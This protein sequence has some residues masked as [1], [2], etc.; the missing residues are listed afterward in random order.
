MVQL[1][2]QPIVECRGLTKIFRDFWMRARVTA[3]DDLNL[4]IIPHEVFGLLGPNGSGKSTTIKIILGL[5]FKT[6]GRVTVLG[7]LPTDVAIKKR[8]GYLPEESY[9]YRFLNARETL[10]YYGRLFHLDRHARNRRIDMLLEMV[11]LDA[12]QRRPVGE[13]SK[14]MQ[15]R[16]G[17]AQALINDPD[18]LILDEPTTGLDPIGT[19]QIKDLIVQLRDRGKTVL[20][21]SHLLADVEDV[22]DR[23]TVLYGGRA[24][25]EGTV[26]ELLTQ[27]D[28]MVIETG[29]LKPDTLNKIEKVLEVEEG[30]AM[31]RVEQ[32]RQKLETLFLNIVHAAQ[33]EGV[34]TSG[35]TSGGN[36]AEFLVRDAHLP[37]DLDGSDVIDRLVADEPVTPRPVE[38]A[39]A[40]PGPTPDTQ[41]DESVLSQLSAPAPV[42]IA[43][44]VQ[45]PAAPADVAE[46]Q[47]SS[48]DEP[49]DRGVID[50]LLG[51]NGK[52]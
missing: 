21:S 4:Q 24:R 29:V 31:R 41:P 19:R 18:L 50:D 42:D 33:T 52:S 49:V 23:V 8:I 34:A 32:P 16:I 26:D 5:L 43:T 48:S 22:C 38:P 10:D 25:A 27:H 20:L 2:E 15:R 44:P 51:P 39:A 40:P 35:A 1:T 17:L 47:E 14:G 46:P 36:V 37:E 45:E 3:V 28:S 7:K 12:V 9:L 13:Y 11:G 6:R 30:Q